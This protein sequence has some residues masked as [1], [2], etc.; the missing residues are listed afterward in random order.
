MSK[1]LYIKTYGCQMNEYDSAR[2]ADSMRE[3]HGLELIT[4]PKNA[5]VILLNTCSIRNKAQEKVFSDLGRFKFLK[6]NNPKLIIGVGGC[7]ASQEK[8]KILQRAPFVDLIFGPQ[9]IH[10]LPEMY[11]NVRHPRP[12][13]HP[14]ASEDPGMPYKSLDSR[15]RSGR[16]QALRGNDNKLG[17][18]DP[19]VCPV[20][21]IFGDGKFDGQKPPVGADPRVCPTT[22]VTIMEGCNKYCSYCI[23]PFTRGQEISR[24]MADVISEVKIL[25]KKGVREIT[26]LGQ[27]VNDYKYNLAKLIHETAK[28]GDIKRIRFT[29]SYPSSLSDE[30]I[31][32]YATE[33]KLADHL[34]L[35]AQSG[36]N[37]ILRAM[38]RRYTVE[39][40]KEK[41]QQMR[42]VRP[43][44]SITSDFIV[45]FPG[46]TEEDFAET[47][48]LIKEIN[49]D[50]S[51]SF[52]Y[53]PRPGT[54]AAKMPDDL[55][56]KNKKQHLAILQKQLSA[57]GAAY[58]EKMLETEQK[59]LVTGWSKKNPQELTGRTENN[60]VVNFA[61]D[62]NL[63][64]KI[65]SVQITGV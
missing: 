32:A 22:F 28:I 52:I 17:G 8:E 27:N 51:F 33:P 50:N 53:S 41:I 11:A 26:F 3:A 25:A 43:N 6:Q 18:T 49:F 57:Q 9:T 38:R 58:S 2:I 4:D 19:C 21:N 30:L 42:A 60:R 47:L 10:R 46:E 61:G 1:K 5:D 59:I 48:N 37:K 13:S 29:T 24:P 23:V 56:L 31:N 20:I 7:V 14:R 16:G 36:S 54:L 44:I 45:G 35:P 39:E 15:P 64:G 65:I 62:K 40:Y 34:H 55:P 12:S 63:I